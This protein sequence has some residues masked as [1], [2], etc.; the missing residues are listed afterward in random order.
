VPEPDVSLLD[1]HVAAALV[2]VAVPFTVVA[3]D[4]DKADTEAFCAAY[5]YSM[6]E[7]ANTIVVVGKSDPPVYAACVLLADSRL[8][9][10]KVVK[11]RLG[12]RRAS[13][14][15][16]E[17]SVALTGQTPGG[18]TPVGLPEGLPLWV[19]A[20]VMRCDRIVVGGGNRRSKIVASPALLLAL[21]AEIVAGLAN[22]IEAAC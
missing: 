13:F 1:P 18:I 9:V 17:A 11:Q 3:C 21:G 7:S 20:A 2:D 16:S 22:P 19:D 15:P 4:E 8:D 10:N 6:S 14:A 5:G 12:T